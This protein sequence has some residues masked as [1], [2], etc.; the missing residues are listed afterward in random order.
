M[1]QGQDRNQRRKTTNKNDQSSV[2]ALRLAHRKFYPE[3]GFIMSSP[4]SQQ[5]SPQL[6]FQT[7]NAYQ[8]TEALKA[9]IDLEVFTAIGEGNTSV[10]E[11]AKRCDA[12]E[13]GIRVL[14]DYLTIMG[15]LTKENNKYG[16]TLDSSVFLDKHSPAYLGGATEFLCDPT[17]T[18]PSRNMTQAVRKGGTTLEGDGSVSHDNPV[19]VKFAR[20]MAPMMAMPAQL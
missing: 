17:L 13:K 7:I 9:A 14:C 16:L 11:I 10:A 15:M 4:A 8:Q 20:A 18:E 1:I 12:S 6:F 19:W 5:P 2:S 3:K